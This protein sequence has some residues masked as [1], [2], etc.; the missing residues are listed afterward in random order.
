MVS[1]IERPSKCSV[2]KPSRE[3]RRNLIAAWMSTGLVIVAIFVGRAASTAF[4]HSRGYATDEA[5]PPGL[6]LVSFLLFALVVFVPTFAALS[7][8][9]RAYHGGLRSGLTAATVAT[10]IS[11]GLLL[12]GLPL[13]LSRLVGWPAVLALGLIVLVTLAFIVSR[14]SHPHIGHV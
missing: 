9:L 1:L 12:L 5:E 8:G 11:G 3:A 14:P 6:G 2:E 10:V 13:F 7:F 4:L